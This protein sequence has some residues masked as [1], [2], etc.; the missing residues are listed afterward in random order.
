M[1]EKNI[2]SHLLKALTER[3]QKGMFRRLAVHFP[4]IDF[5]S[6]DYL[7]FSK[8]G[9]LTEKLK[10]SSYS[11][12]HYGSGGSRLISGNTHFIEEAEKQI[13]MFHHA[14]SALIFNSGYMANLGILSSVPQKD[15]LVIYDELIHASMHDGIRLGNATHYKFRH[16]DVDSL[17][18][19]IQRHH[20]NFKNIFIVVESVY[21]MDGDLAPLLE[22]TELIKNM[23]HAFL[24]VDEAHAIGVFGNQGRGL[25]SALGIEN[26]C[27]ARIYT[28]GKSMGCHG[29]AIVGSE[30]LR[31]FLINFS[32]PFIYTTAPPNSC[33]DAI[34]HAYQL[35]IETSQKEL[36]QDNISYFYSRTSGIK[37]M[38]KS[39]SAIHSLLVGS[40]EKADLLEQELEKKNIHAKAV[41]SPTVKAGTERIRFCIHS[42]NTKGEIDLLLGSLAELTK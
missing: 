12:P 36:L 30:I 9:L 27:F 23:E 3:Q 8:T 11:S 25:C 16:N 2:P 20:A 37:N 29:A 6:N 1:A 17:K 10:S 22:I 38:I 28:Y 40:N 31:S 19:L 15:D 41:K 33:I 24:I 42:Y 13:A 26:Q 14:K 32:R 34:L 4:E 21:S 18:D 35:L 39:Q 5:C 7:G